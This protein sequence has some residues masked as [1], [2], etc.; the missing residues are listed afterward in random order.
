MPEELGR[1]GG[2]RLAVG[3][4]DALGPG[5]QPQELAGA[6]L[7]VCRGTSDQTPDIGVGSDKHN[8]SHARPMVHDRGLEGRGGLK[9]P[10]AGA[11]CRIFVKENTLCAGIS[12]D[13]WHIGDEFTQEG[14]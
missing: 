5:G 1:S 8:R 6:V 10:I 11:P 7:P 3:L 4:N 12:P 9:K 13:L 2:T 14:L